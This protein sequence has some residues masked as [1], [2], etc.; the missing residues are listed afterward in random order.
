MRLRRGL[1]D[2]HLG[3]DLA[4]VPALGEQAQGLSL[5]LGEVVGECGRCP[6]GG[7]AGELLV[8]LTRPWVGDAGAALIFAFLLVASLTLATQ[9]TP[10]GLARGRDLP[11]QAHPAA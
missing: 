1:A 9:L 10:R 5:A 6:P 4:V 7:V 3:R 8:G 11:A 2:E